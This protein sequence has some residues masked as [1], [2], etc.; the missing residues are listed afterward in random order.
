MPELTDPFHVLSN[1]EITSSQKG[2]FYSLPELEKQGVGP[3]SRL[4]FSIR[5]VLESVLRNCDGH[6]I[7]QEDVKRLANWNAKKPVEEETVVDLTQQKFEKLF[8]IV[9]C[10]CQ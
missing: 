8:R 6:K 2:F 1:F 3:I 9:N 10:K 7:T 4:P 5:V